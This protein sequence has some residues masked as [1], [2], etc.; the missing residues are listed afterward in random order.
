MVRSLVNELKSNSDLQ[1]SIQDSIP[2]LF[3]VA[4]SSIKVNR[5][6]ELLLS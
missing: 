1:I 2:D 5:T 4:F 6:L 3:S